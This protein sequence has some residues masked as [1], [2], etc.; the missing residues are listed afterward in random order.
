MRRPHWVSLRYSK[1]YWLQKRLR[2]AAKFNKKDVI[3][4]LISMGVSVN[5]VNKKN[6]SAL[7]HAVANDNIE[8]AELLCANGAEVQ[9]KT[10]DILFIAIIR[11]NLEMI[12]MLLNYGADL[13]VKDQNGFDCIRIACHAG[14]A[15]DGNT[16]SLKYLISIGADMEYRTSRLDITS[17]QFCV[18]FG[19]VHHALILLRA[20]ASIINAT[21]D[22]GKSSLLAQ[23]C[24][25]TAPVAEELLLN[26]G[27]D[28]SEI[29]D[30]A[31]L[32]HVKVASNH[33]VCLL[34][35]NNFNQ[36][37]VDREQFCGR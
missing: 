1:L 37:Y 25:S 6:R 9:H 35:Y 32:D 20:G 28:S 22:N 8:A 34:Q 18:Q 5:A 26:F 27:C 24:L 2:L 30:K 13:E 11:N 7:F 12:I 33:F 16:D 29:N 14:F 10:N 15:M 23:C 31:L 4:Q 36:W 3:E 17:L 19:L 21:G